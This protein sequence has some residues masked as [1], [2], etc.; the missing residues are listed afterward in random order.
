MASV[1]PAFV[2]EEPE[3]LPGSGLCKLSQ[4]KSNWLGQELLYFLEE[5]ELALPFQLL[6]SSLSS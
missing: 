4:P 5:K 1:I 3:G 6:N 2:V